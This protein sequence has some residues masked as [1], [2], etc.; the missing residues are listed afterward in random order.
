MADLDVP[1]DAPLPESIAVGAGTAVFVAG[2]CTAPG[3]RLRSLEV[4]VDGEP[5]PVTASG[6]PRLDVVRALHPGED[7]YAVVDPGAYRSGF[8]A[9]VRIG[10]PTGG[11]VALDLRARLA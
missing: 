1:L 4:L 7:P 9:T 10:R 3:G 8:W 2:W 5:Q 11:E 6:M